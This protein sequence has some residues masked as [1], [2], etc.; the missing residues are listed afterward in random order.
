MSSKPHYLGPEYS[1]RFKD[2]SLVEAYPLRSP[3]PAEIFE[4]LTGLITDEPRA[5]LDVG[6]GTG[7]IAR[8]LAY[9]VERVDAV[10]FSLPMIEKGRTLPGGDHPNLT[11]VYGRAEDAPFNPPYAL[12]TAGQALH[13][14]DWGIVLPRFRK[15]L[16][17]RGYLA[18]VDTRELPLLWASELGKIIKRFS[19]NP[20]YQ[21]V[22]LIKEL[23]KR[24]LFQQSGEK[25][26]APVSFVQSIDDSVESGVTLRYCDILCYRHAPCSAKP[27]TLSTVRRATQPP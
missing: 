14:M 21:P 27:R 15:A 12:V 25:Q 24:R 13:W 3:Y 18:I 11:W 19:T 17:P 20:D 10:D 5:V 26:T 8:P 22:D 7:N 16:T 1:N 6:C 23:E 9:L 2:S 4:M